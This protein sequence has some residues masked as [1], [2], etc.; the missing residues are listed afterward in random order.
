MAPHPCNII[1][2]GVRIAARRRP[3]RALNHLQEQFPLR[4]SGQT[5]L[6][7]NACQCNMAIRHRPRTK[8]SYKGIHAMQVKRNAPISHTGEKKNYESCSDETS[9]LRYRKRASSNRRVSR[10]G[11]IGPI[12]LSSLAKPSS[13]PSTPGDQYTLSNSPCPTNC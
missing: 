8:L 7:Q 1:A 13:G 3:L 2:W 4:L 12:S 9:P 6:G 10:G 5:T 11:R